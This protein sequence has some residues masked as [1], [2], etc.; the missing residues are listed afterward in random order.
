MLIEQGALHCLYY[1][2][3]SKETGLIKKT[4]TKQ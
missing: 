2:D 4:K 1:Q 3:L